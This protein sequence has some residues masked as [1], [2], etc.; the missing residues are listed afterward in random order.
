MP[1]LLLTGA[2]RGIGIEFARQ[3]AEAGW[4][5]VATVRDPAQAKA[6]GALGA[7]VEPLDM[8]DLAAVE[9]FPERLGSAP[10]DLFIANAGITAAPTIDSAAQAQAWTRCMR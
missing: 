2:G 4:D 10:L 7:R 5:V 3:Y 6:L 9:A 1:A 8:R